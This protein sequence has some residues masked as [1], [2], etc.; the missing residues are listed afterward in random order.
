M[1][2]KSAN[3]SFDPDMFLA[4]VN[5]GRCISE[6]RTRQVIFSQGDASNSVFYI[7][8]GKVKIAVTSEGGGKRSSACSARGSFSAK[9]V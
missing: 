7:V 4:T 5:H 9:A 3:A 6:Y 2:T 1:A 8:R